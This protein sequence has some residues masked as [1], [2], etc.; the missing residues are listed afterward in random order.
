MVA[1]MIVKANINLQKVEGGGG[2]EIPATL[3][4]GL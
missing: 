1:I 2:Y 3:M 4:R